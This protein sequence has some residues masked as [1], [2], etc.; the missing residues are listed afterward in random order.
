MDLI[1]AS[2]QITLIGA[3]GEDCT[4]GLPGV[5]RNRNFAGLSVDVGFTTLRLE[6]DDHSV[7]SRIELSVWFTRAW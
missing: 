3:A 7:T 5:G 2:A 4:Y 6:L 1:Y